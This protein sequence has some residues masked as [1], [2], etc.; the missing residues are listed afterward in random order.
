MND[1][2]RK[3]KMDSD[4]RSLIPIGHPLSAYL[5]RVKVDGPSKFG[6][7]YLRSV[8]TDSQIRPRKNMVM[9]FSWDLHSEP[10]RFKI[11]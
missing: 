8:R 4:R 9:S 5:F 7:L 10:K 11:F 6:G 1:F 2:E 3:S